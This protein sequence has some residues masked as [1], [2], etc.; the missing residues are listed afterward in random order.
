MI[1]RKRK[2]GMMQTLEP[3]NPSTLEPLKEGWRWVRLGEVCKII[4]GQSPAG[5][6]YNSD[7]RGVPLLNG[8]TEFGIINP[9]P[10]QWTTSPTQF[11]EVGDILLCVRGATTGRKNVADKK[12]CIGRGLAAIRGRDD[13]AIN[14]FL[15]YCLDIATNSLL[16]ETSGS[17]FPNLPR[18]KLYGIKIPLPPIS[19]QKR[20]AAK[21]Q[22]LTQE[23]ERA[24]TSCE[25]QLAAAKA[26]PAAYLREVFESE[27][28]KKWERKRLGEV[29][30][31][32]KNGIVAEQNFE[33]KGSQVTRIETISDGVIDSE[34]IGWVNLLR[35]NFVDFKLC[36]GDILFSHINSVEKLGNC[37]IYEGTPENLYHGMNLLRIK[38]DED[39]LEP[40]FF[41]YWLRSD[42]CQNYYI[43][44]ARR[45]IG[46]ASLNQKDIKQMPIYLPPRHI[47]HRIASELKEK[48]AEV[49]NLQST[50]LNQKSAI[51]AMP[52]AILRKAFRGEL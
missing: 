40:Y 8:P 49:E 43:T 6:S 4:M 19:E 27:E 3:L 30:L 36:K 47:Q 41:L 45:A 10:V 9:T 1:T 35:D 13:N 34:K 7:G 25:K 51:E 48:M 37:A 12:Y 46:Q 15:W 14:E 39:I 42:V 29:I 16:R 2:T 33:G 18:E 22:E 24:R 20:I 31:F 44:N 23:V 28:A 17:T 26:L 11:A 5:S 21:I 38:V 32:I 50:I 52:Q